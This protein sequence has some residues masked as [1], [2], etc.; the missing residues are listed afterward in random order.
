V[1]LHYGVKSKFIQEKSYQLNYV[2]TKDELEKIVF[3]FDL[4]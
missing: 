3:L 1:G 2:Q 4:G